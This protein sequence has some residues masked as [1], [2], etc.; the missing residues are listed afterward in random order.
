MSR[1]LEQNDAK[2]NRIKETI[3][4]N[5]TNLKNDSN[6]RFDELEKVTQDNLE[7]NQIKISSTKTD[8]I[9]KIN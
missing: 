2:M 8:L 1:K 7:Q 5:I 6:T 3:E 4:S 9:M